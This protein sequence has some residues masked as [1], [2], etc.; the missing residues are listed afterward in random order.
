MGWTNISGGVLSCCEASTAM[1]NVTLRTEE[2]VGKYFK[3][4]LIFINRLNVS[5]SQMN[6]S[7]FHLLARARW[8]K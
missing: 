8:L 3:N 5:L 7:R 6:L 2:N 1:A 4:I